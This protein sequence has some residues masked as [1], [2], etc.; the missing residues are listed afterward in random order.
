[1]FGDV[2]RRTYAYAVLIGLVIGA[3][4][5][6]PPATPA[7]SFGSPELSAP[8]A[9]RYLVTTEPIVVGHG[10][11]Q[12]VALDPLSTDGVWIWGPGRTGCSTRSTG[13]D[14]IPAVGARITPLPDTRQFLVSY[15]LELI[16]SGSIQVQLLVD[17][18]S[19]RVGFSRTAQAVPIEQRQ[20]LAIPEAP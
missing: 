13:P 10:I 15:D 9:A 1:M 12:C 3:C 4:Q 20:D 16:P 7:E 18:R 14:V 6:I 5:A 19:I 2:A 8:A 11:E 17:D